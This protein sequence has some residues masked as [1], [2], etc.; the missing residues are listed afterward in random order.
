M[1]DST[2]QTLTGSTI[3]ECH[4]CGALDADDDVLLLYGRV[5]SCS[6]CYQDAMPWVDTDCPTCGD[7]GG[8]EKIRYGGRRECQDCYA[9]RKR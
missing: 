6:D 9:R 4:I 7:P 3:S 1:V 2:Q 5:V 8:P